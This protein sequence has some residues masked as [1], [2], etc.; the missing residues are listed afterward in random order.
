MRRTLLKDVSSCSYLSV[1]A[2]ADTSK[3]FSVSFPVIHAVDIF[4]FLKCENK[5]H[6]VISHINC[7]SK[8]HS[9]VKFAENITQFTPIPNLF[10]L[11]NVQ[12]CQNCQ[13]CALREN[14]KEWVLKP[15]LLFVA[16][17]SIVIKGNHFQSLNLSSRS[18][19]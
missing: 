2:T 6:V 4:E 10:P 1:L 12:K 11:E 3:F 19:G 15:V 9:K 5:L 8:H 14:S 16:A 18:A 17:K 7:I 13:C